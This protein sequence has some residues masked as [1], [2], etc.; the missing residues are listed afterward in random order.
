MLY[1]APSNNH[2]DLARVFVERGDDVP[3]QDK[4]G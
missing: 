2:A 3:A 4:G 1:L